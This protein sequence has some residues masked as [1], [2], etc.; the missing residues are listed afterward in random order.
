[1]AKLITLNNGVSVCDTEILAKVAAYIYCTSATNTDVYNW[2]IDFADIE[3]HFDLP[4]GFIDNAMAKQIKKVLCKEFE[5]QIAECRVF[6]NR[7]KNEEIRGCF[8]VDVYTD[9]IPNWTED[10]TI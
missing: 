2:I 8:S 6:G 3:E 7:G 10:G 9:F 4:T 5:N 1:M